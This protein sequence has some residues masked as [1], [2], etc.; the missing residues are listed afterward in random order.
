M[1]LK[2]LIFDFDGVIADSE[3]CHLSA[4]NQTFAEFGIELDPVAYYEKYLGCTDWEL[5]DDVRRDYK[6]D[7]K[8]RTAKQLAGQKTEIFHKLI[9]RG[10]SIIDGIIEFVEELKKNNI[11]I[12]VNSGA[13]AADIELMLKGTKIEK[14]F[15]VIVTADDIEK[16]KPDPQGYLLTLKKLNDNSKEKIF[17]GDCAVIED[18]KWGIIAAQKAGMRT[19]GIT[20]SY[21][22]KELLGS[23][24]IIDSVRHLTISALHKLCS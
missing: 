15:E 17:A 4:F 10:D 18:S 22:A 8:G 20:N 2:A 13:T 14:A 5:I 3:P 12:A 11:R 23:D 9:G 1:S 21:P 7:F 16:G 6:A 19:I 24:L